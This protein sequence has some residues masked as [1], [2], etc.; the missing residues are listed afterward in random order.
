MRE[1]LACY[2]FTGKLERMTKSRDLVDELEHGSL[3]LVV[4]ASAVVETGA[5]D[6]VDLVEENLNMGSKL[7]SAI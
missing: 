1:L 2:K 7:R 4:A 3:D 6:G 5:T